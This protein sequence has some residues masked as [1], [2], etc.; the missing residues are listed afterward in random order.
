MSAPTFKIYS[1]RQRFLKHMLESIGRY[2]LLKAA[3]G[4]IDFSDPK[5][6]VEAIFPELA[7]ADTSK[8]AA[9]LQQVV[10]GCV[11][12]IAQGLL[13]KA[14]CVALINAIAGRLGVEIDA[15]EELAKAADEAATRAQADV[16]TTPPGDGA[17]GGAPAKPTDAVMKEAMEIL[18]DWRA[19]LDRR[20]DAI[21]QAGASGANV[22]E[23]IAEQS[24]NTT[25]L[26]EALGGAVTRHE[27]ELTLKHGKTKKTVS[28]PDGRKFGLAEEDA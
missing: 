11:Q 18:A 1:M 16:F 4:A 5:N 19:G 26:V 8:Y 22:T 3:K 24:K 7:A 23:L 28:L 12:A 2:V 9:A 27:L 14:T 10:A 6:K 20:L 13:S 21:A 17:V 25:R 15:E